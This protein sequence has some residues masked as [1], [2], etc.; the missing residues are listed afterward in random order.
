[1]SQPLALPN[2]HSTEL[3][4]LSDIIARVPSLALQHDTPLENVGDLLAGAK[5]E[6][7]GPIVG[8]HRHNTY[9]GDNSRP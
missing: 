2:H 1:M 4:A 8:Y 7:F 6:L 9:S 5:F 3:I